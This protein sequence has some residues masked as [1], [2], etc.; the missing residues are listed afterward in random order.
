MSVRRLVVEVD[1]DGLNVAEF[2]R[3]HGISRWFFY[4]L[5]RR[6]A[7]EGEAGLVPRSRAPKRVANRT[8][9]RVEDLIVDVRKRLIEDGLD[10]GAATIRFHLAGR[11]DR[12]P[13]EATIW[14]VL[15]RRGFVTPHPE[16]APKHAF[17]RFEADRV[18]ECWQIDDTS[19]MLADGTE[20]KVINL[21]DD[22]SRVVV[23]SKAVSACTGETAYQV[24][25]EAAD[26]WGLPVW[27][28]ADNAPAF[29]YRLA[30]AVTVHGVR[31]SSSRPYH[32]QTCGK[33]ERF[34]Q[35]LKKWLGSRPRAESL[36]ELQ[37][38]LDTFCQI[39]NYQRPHRS[40]AR[41]FP[42]VVHAAGPQAGPTDRPLTPRTRIHQVTVIE[43]RVDVNKDW[44][45][46][47]GN[48]WDGQPATV[49][50]TGHHCHV[51]IGGTLA[52]Q[53]TLDP[54]RRYQPLHPRPGR[55][56]VRKDP[57]HV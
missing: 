9:G 15:T 33:V 42:A 45:I 56:P 24:F 11:V 35:T 26:E 49:I 25:L 39:Y 13:S 32:P 40:L 16:R 12:V 20:V 14:R 21:L 48:Q 44:T 17:R 51:L 23:G 38:Q 37:D 6:Y 30:E 29:K 3:Q 52:R 43:G 53:L 28:L 22:R 10:A 27:V 55:P 1:D 47:V 18:N 57:R 2:C 50:I 41:R 4:E 31:S 7:A 34:H 36:G 19:W 46:A 5:R 54:D 8:G